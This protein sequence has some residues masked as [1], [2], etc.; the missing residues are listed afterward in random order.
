MFCV[1][2]SAKMEVYANPENNYQHFVNAFVRKNPHGEQKQIIKKANELWKTIKDDEKKVKEFIRSAP[3][4]KKARQSK[5]TFGKVSS[6][7]STTSTSSLQPSIQERQDNIR[8][9]QISL[10]SLGD[11]ADEASRN[12]PSAGLSFEARS[13]LLYCL[14][15]S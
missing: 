7:E 8:Q 3:P 2:Q 5:I 14:T 10:P 1:W 4:K 12:S 6:E 9:D 13:V 15:T 11:F